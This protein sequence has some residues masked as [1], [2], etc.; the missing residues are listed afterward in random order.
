MADTSRQ[1]EPWSNST[2]LGG[3]GPLDSAEPAFE[4][5]A[6][7]QEEAERL[8]EEDVQSL[9]AV[10]ISRAQSRLASPRTPA[11][12]KAAALEQL[13]GGGLFD[14]IARETQE[15]DFYE[16]V[17]TT[18]AQASP[19][20]LPSP[21]RASPKEFEKTL[22]GNLDHKDLASTSHQRS[23]SGTLFSGTDNPF[24]RLMATPLPS[25][26]KPGQF[27]NFFPNQIPFFTSNHA[28]EKP[29]QINV[30]SKRSN[31]LFQSTNL[32]W[33]VF[34]A[35][36]D[37]QGP[38]NQTLS[39]YGAQSGI[40]GNP[41]YGNGYTVDTLSRKR[42]SGSL[43]KASSDSSLRLSRDISRVSSLGDDAH[44][45]DVQ[46]QVN[47]RFKAIK[48]SFADSSFKLPNLPSKFQF[49]SR[50]GIQKGQY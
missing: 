48:D 39:E 28:S 14:D 2:T 34:S 27:T 6:G 43:H 24:K 8:Q 50:I 18:G 45:H 36:A 13:D 12:E 32:P 38:M 41:H 7:A 49:S 10:S 16:Y 25:L 47:S 40:T 44:F 22:T 1:E 35:K 26:P 3:K 20:D 19:V 4:N 42:T 21:W 29:A 46:G 5:V 15:E 33:N 30:R 37:S 23:S 11:A 17:D 31:S 9:L